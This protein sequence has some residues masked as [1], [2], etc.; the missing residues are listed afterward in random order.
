M[1][2]ILRNSPSIVLP[3]MAQPKTS[4]VRNV[5]DAGVCYQELTNCIQNRKQGNTFLKQ[6]SE[7][8]KV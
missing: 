6:V 4:Y 2:K 5:T 1:I 8:L 3:S 7:N